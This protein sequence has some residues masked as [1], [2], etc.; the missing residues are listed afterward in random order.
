[1]G[2]VTTPI[3]HSVVNFTQGVASEKCDR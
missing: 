2:N 3:L 1:M